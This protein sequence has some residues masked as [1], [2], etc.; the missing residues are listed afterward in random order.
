M[1]DKHITD[2]EILSKTSLSSESGVLCLYRCCP[3]C[4]DTLR[5]L[6]QKILI[7]KWGS[8][9]SLWTAE[10][11]HDIVASVSV[12]L[13]AAIRRMNVSG[14]SSNLLDDKMRDGNNESG[15]QMPHHQREHPNKRKCFPEYSSQA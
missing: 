12:D 10:D 8:N 3:T 2:V 6:T 7:H 1:L 13:L 15:M 9:R 11:V 5:S 14:G 4:L